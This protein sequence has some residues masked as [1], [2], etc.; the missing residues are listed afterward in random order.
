MTE[1]KIIWESFHIDKFKTSETEKILEQLDENDEEEALL[2]EEIRNAPKLI[3][4]PQGLY[5]IDD[6]MNPFNSM[7]CR[8]AICNFEI[9]EKELIITNFFAGVEAVQPVSRYKMLVGFAQLFDA[10]TVRTELTKQLI[11]IDTYPK[12]LLIKQRNILNNSINPN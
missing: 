10:Q 5:Q 2:A 11:N 9:T 6:S 8:L 7:E 1:R 12:D 4:T 3:D